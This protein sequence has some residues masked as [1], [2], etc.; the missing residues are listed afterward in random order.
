[1]TGWWFQT[2]FI[3]HDIWDNPSHL[4]THIFQMV[5][6]TNQMTVFHTWASLHQ[7]IP[8]YLITFPRFEDSPSISQNPSLSDLPCRNQ[9]WQWKRNVYIMET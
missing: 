7:G 1:M 2:C 9:T 6:T 5:K 8:S 3:V 4:R